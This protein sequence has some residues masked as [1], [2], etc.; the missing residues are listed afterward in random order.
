ML[1]EEEYKESIQ[2]LQNDVV[3]VTNQL[4]S[5]RAELENALRIERHRNHELE[6]K[7]HEKMDELEHVNTSFSDLVHQLSMTMK[8]LDK[9]KKYV[10]HL[11]IH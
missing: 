10:C 7:L 8:E 3:D 6:E 11:T 5:T 4:T 2:K 9:A 1:Q